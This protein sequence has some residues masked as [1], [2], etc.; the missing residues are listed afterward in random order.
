MF[1]VLPSLVLGKITLEKRLVIV[2]NALQSIMWLSLLMWFIPSLIFSVTAESW[3]AFLDRPM[4]TNVIFLLPLLVPAVIL[5][6]AV[7]EF[8]MNGNGTAF[9][10]DP[11]DKLVMSGIYGH[12]SNPMQLGICLL[13]AYWGIVLDSLVVS[14]TALVAIMMFIV[15]KA[16]RAGRRNS[17]IPSAW[18]STTPRR[19]TVRWCTSWPACREP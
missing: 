5:G 3:N 1:C 7:K 8:A 12:L 19:S 9:P 17:A 11:P 6:S 4:H 2:R 16:C 13:M 15:F 18:P 14:A 10:F